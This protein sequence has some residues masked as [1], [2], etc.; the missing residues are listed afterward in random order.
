MADK[1]LKTM[2]GFLVIR[3]MQIEVDTD[4]VLKYVPTLMRK[5]TQVSH[6]QAAGMLRR[7]EM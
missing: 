6:W 7:L 4:H 3:E 1:H 5:S 2:P